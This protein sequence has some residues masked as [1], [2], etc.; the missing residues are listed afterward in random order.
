[1]SKF[2]FAL[3]TLLV[4]TF[5]SQAG[6]DSNTDIQDLFVGLPT[7]PFIQQDKMYSNFSDVNG[8]FNSTDNGTIIKTQYFP[9]PT[10]HDVHTVTFNGLFD[11]SKVYDIFYTISVIPSSAAFITSVGLGINQSFGDGIPAT[12]RK[13][14]KDVDGNELWNSGLV[15]G[16]TNDWEIA[17]HK[18]LFIEDILTVNGASVNGISN[19]FVQTGVAIPSVPE[20]ATMMLLGFGLVGLAGLRKKI[21]S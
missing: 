3:C 18:I 17:P 13:I 1:M 7:T 8:W 5:A 6:A 10:P 4:L 2:V 16:N 14:V 21:K 12:L 19:S 11:Y 9:M 15:T 20:P